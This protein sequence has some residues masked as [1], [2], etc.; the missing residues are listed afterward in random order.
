MQATFPENADDEEAKPNLYPLSNEGT[1]HSE[2]PKEKPEWKDN[3]LFIRR[4]FAESPSQGCA[5]LFRRYHKILCSHAV[6][7]VYSK[8]IAEDLVS[9]VFCRFWKTKAYETVMTSYRLY[10]FRSVRNEAL[11]YLRW[12]FKETETIELAE[13]RESPR[14]QQPDHATQY[15]EVFRKVEELVETLPP[16][17]QKVFLLNRFEGKKYQEIADEMNISIK[18]VEVHLGKALSIMRNGLKNH[19]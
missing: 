19:L 18:T 8:D 6:R 5:L 9:E 1:D 16:Q 13:Y 12:E 17:C 2:L 15:E 14:S 4:T 3:E 7:F 11:N 10:L